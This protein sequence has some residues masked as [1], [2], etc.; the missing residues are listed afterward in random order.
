VV[1]DLDSA[2][3]GDLAWARAE[4]AEI[5]RFPEDKERTDLELALDRADA[6]GVDRI[7]AVGVDG[8]R[9]DHELG[10]WAALSAMRTALVE[11]HTAHGTATILHGAGH[12]RAELSGTEGDVVSLLPRAGDAI[13]VTTEGLRWPLSAATLTATGTRGI[14]NEFVGSSA[15]VE[16]DRGILMV[17]RPRVS[18]LDS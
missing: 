3:E 12:R 4:G 7:V 10:N 18:P 13:G 16:V 8:G 2:T 17:V 9:L 6:S 11:V 5:V 15:S 1:G 14:S